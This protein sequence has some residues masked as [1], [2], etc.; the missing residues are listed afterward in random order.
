MPSQFRRLFYVPRC[1]RISR[2]RAGILLAPFHVF[3]EAKYFS[4][5]SSRADYSRAEPVDQLARE[6]DNLQSIAGCLHAK[7]YLIYLTKDLGCPSKEIEESIREYRHKRPGDTDPP[8]I[9][10]LSWRRLS[11]MDASNP[12]RADLI[13][14]VNRLGLTYFSGFNL[15]ARRPRILWTFDR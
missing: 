1:R 10:W 14:M 13:E 2:P 4:G 5:K 11:E 3:V 12:I 8:N 15:G 7:T 9:L 6:W